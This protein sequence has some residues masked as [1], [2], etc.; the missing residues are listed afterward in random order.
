MD[1]KGL[2]FD[3]LPNPLIPLRFFL[4]APLFGI[5][6]ACL[7]FVYGQTAWLSRWHPA[8]LAIT[9]ALTLGVIACVIMAALHQLLPVISGKQIPLAKF[10][11]P[12][13][14]VV[15]I[16]G[17]LL[18]IMAFVNG[19]QLV[20]TLS[21]ALLLT[22]FTLYLL[23]L[24][25]ALIQKSKIG[26]TLFGIQLG[27]VSLL[28]LLILAVI[29]TSI[30]ADLLTGNIAKQLTNLHATWGLFGWVSITLIGVSYQVVPMFHVTPAFPGWFQKFA[31]LSLIAFLIILTVLIISEVLTPQLL[32]MMMLIPL[33][34]IGGFSIMV[35]LQLKNRKRKIPDISIN[36]WQ[37][38]CIG[39]IAL[40]ILTL[41]QMF[42]VLDYSKWQLLA[43]Y[44]F[45]VVFVISVIHALIIKVVPFICYLNLQQLCMT[46]LENLKHLPHMHQFINTRKAKLLFALHV[47]SCIFGIA[48]ILKPSLYILPAVSFFVQ[49]CWLFAL[50]LLATTRYLE[51][52][53][54]MTDSKNLVQTGSN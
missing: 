31:P 54:R 21:I 18:L 17:T 26:S 27:T 47:F 35:L 14:H 19:R 24:I 9:H 8:Q 29:I 48:A 43:G 49:Y 32:N 25:W 1:M 20:F 41:L 22:S 12:R 50:I 28:I 6:A 7:M 42:S 51:S 46:N 39:I 44:L 33:I 4:S 3:D 36:F 13:V 5:L 15:H 2:T 37:L 30:R 53:K 23:P 10:T 38:A 11:S 45:I 16:T 34:S 52:K 40:T